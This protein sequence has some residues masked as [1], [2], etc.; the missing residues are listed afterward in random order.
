MRHLGTEFLVER[1]IDDV[2]AELLVGVVRDAQ[3]GPALVIGSGGVR[4]ELLADSATLLLPTNTDEVLQAIRCLRNYPLLEGFRGA[5]AGDI[6]A[7]VATVLRVADYAIAHRR[8]L[9]EL[10]INPLLVLPRGKGAVAA[11]AFIRVKKGKKG[12]REGF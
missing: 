2:V 7:V 8:D 1:M 6:N 5:P 3:F 12:V 4:V 10:D 9:L 11:D